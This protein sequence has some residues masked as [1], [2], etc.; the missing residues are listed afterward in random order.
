M[1]D[2][3]R[4]VT[5]IITLPPVLLIHLK[6]WF[7][8]E[9]LVKHKNNEHV[10]YDFTFPWGATSVY[11]LTAV[12]VHEGEDNIGHYVAFVRQLNGAWF[13]YDDSRMPEEVPSSSVAA[14][15]AYLLFYVA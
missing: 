1:R 13:K 14:Q 11:S 6:R 12:V 8:D 2:T 15:I 3:S 5:E 10:T 4:K 9:H 7:F